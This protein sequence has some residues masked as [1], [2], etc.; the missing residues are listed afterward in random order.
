MS[1]ILS[2]SPRKELSDDMR[3][4]LSTK[5]AEFVRMLKLEISPL[6]GGKH[7]LGTLWFMCTVYKWLAK[8]LGV[9]MPWPL[10]VSDSFGPVGSNYDPKLLSRNFRDVLRELKLAPPALLPR[11]SVISDPIP[12]QQVEPPSARSV[13]S[14]SSGVGDTDDLNGGLSGALPAPGGTLPCAVFGF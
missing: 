3:K 2:L 1:A 14:P 10:A 6:V 8:R 5:P 4:Q 7:V 13:P 11:A 12:Y 9:E